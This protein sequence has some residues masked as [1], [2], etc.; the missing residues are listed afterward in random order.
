MEVE[1]DNRLKKEPFFTPFSILLILVTIVVMVLIQV[2]LFPNLSG[3]SYFS[4]NALGLLFVVLDIYVIVR[5]YLRRNGLDKPR[6]ADLNK[7]L[8]DAYTAK[9][10]GIRFRGGSLGRIDVYTTYLPALFNKSPVNLFDSKTPTILVR[11]SFLGRLD[12]NEMDAVVLHEL[13]HYMSPWTTVKKFLALG[14]MPISACILLAGLAIIFYRT[15]ILI[16]LDVIIGI[17]ILDIG[18]YTCFAIVYWKEEEK[19]DLFSLKFIKRDFISSALVKSAKYIGEEFG[20]SNFS[21]ASKYM[22]KRLNKLR[23]YNE[24]F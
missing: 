4:M 14:I 11:S 17:V 10:G 3:I 22:R 5:S 13:Y 7:E 9:F 6:H 21:K 24:T 15:E 19:A 20:N 12:S 16:L 1:N 23:E 18:F 8:S 2:V